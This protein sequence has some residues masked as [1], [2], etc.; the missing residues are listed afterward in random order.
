MASDVILTSP[1]DVNRVAGYEHLA[2]A[3]GFAF[4]AGQVARDVDGNWVGGDDA[5]AQ[6][7]Q[8]YRNIGRILAHIGAAPTQVVKINTILVDRADSAD[9]TRERLAFF[10]DHRPPHTGVIVAG[11]GS[12]HVKIEVEIIVHVGAGVGPA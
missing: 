1:P 7:A 11:L 6:A 2:I 5:G 8:I 12:P 10:G 4:V 3:G 9:V